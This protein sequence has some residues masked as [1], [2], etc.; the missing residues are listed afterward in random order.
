MSVSRSDIL[1]MPDEQTAAEAAAAWNWLIPEPWRVV[2]CSMFGGLF[3]EKES[4]GVF[5]LECG[6]GLV[7]RVADSAG[8]FQAYL[9]GPRDEAWNSRIDEWFLWNFVDQLHEAG[10]RPGPGQCYGLTILP[11]FAE[12]RYTV[13]NVFVLSAREW[14]TVTGSM[15]RQIQDLPDG[16]QVAIK[17]VD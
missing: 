11:V 6:T 13:D 9:G 15:H 1:F 2:V 16:A 10:K 17:V 12:G 8:A 14:L 4:G 3:L 7:E 5:W